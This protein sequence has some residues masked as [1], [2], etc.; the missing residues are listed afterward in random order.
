MDLVIDGFNNRY[1]IKEF[2]DGVIEEGNVVL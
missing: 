2:K 1:E